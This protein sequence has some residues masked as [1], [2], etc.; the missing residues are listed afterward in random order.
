MYVEMVTRFMATDPRILSLFMEEEYI[1]FILFHRSG[2]M[3]T[4]AR[5]V[6]R[7]T[8]EGLSFSSIEQFVKVQR[9]QK[10][11]SVQLKVA[12]ILGLHHSQLSGD[13]ETIIDMQKPY[14]S[15]DLLCKCFLTNFAEHRRLYFSQMSSLATSTYISID[16][17]FKVTANIGYLRADGKWITQ[18]NSL[19]IVLNNIG[20]VIAWQ[21]TRT[22][23]IDECETLLS[24][25]RYRCTR[26]GKPVM[27]VYVDNC[28]QSRNK[29]QSVFRAGTRAFLDIFH[30]TQRIIKTISKRHPLCH[31]IM[32]DIK[33]LFRDPLDIGKVRTLATP[34]EDILLK[35]I[36]YFISKWKYVSING[37]HIINEKTTRVTVP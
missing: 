25:L 32:N 15:N 9:E 31:S 3:R 7:L 16:H 18:Y 27:E 2:V 21:F 1:P 8:I 10:I 14:P 33:L 4:F 5:L 17:T 12:S 20:Q 13:L 36:E 11:N 6:I 37:W 23:S 26:L 28:C 35:N 19:F 24:G 30:A 34:G 22:T 29:L